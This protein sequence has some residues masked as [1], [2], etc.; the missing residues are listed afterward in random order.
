M[1]LKQHN[2]YMK[3]DEPP[4]LKVPENG[5]LPQAALEADHIRQVFTRMGFTD[6]ETVA[7]I[8]AH[9]IGR[10]HTDRSGYKGFSASPNDSNPD[11]KHQQHGL[12][13]Q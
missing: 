8:G 3:V 2:A 9:C 11:F 10:C 4:T 7:L 13:P 12:Q 6:Q 5:R 1:I